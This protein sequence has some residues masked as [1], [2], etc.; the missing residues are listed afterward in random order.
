M[1]VNISPTLTHIIIGLATIGSIVGLAANGTVTGSEAV[2][3]ITGVSG[4]LLGTSA[5]AVGAATSSPPST[6]SSG[7]ATPAELKAA[8][9]V[10]QNPGT[11]SP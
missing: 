10:A 8:A 1:N 2:A 3:V 6:I 5:T 11:V 9:S 4:V 7:A